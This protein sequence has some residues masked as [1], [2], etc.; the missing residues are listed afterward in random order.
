MC[1]I[2]GYIG[3]RNA[4]PILLEGLKR[5]EYRGYDSAGI[6]FYENGG[7]VVKKTVG[8]LSNLE[9]KINGQEY[10]S[11]IG[12]GHTRWATHGRPT[13]I[14][15][16]PHCDC[17]GRVVV[18]HNGIIENHA[19]LRDALASEGHVF[20]SQTDTE[21]V[22]HL[23][24]KYLVECKDLRD[25]VLRA[26]GE[27]KGTFALAVISNLNPDKMVV[28]R[29]SSPLVIGCGR[30]EY[31]VASDVTPLLRYTRDAIFLD[32]NEIAVLDKNGLEVFD[33]ESGCRK[34]KSTYHVTW[35]ADLAEKNGYPHF[36]LKE[37]HEQPQAI[38]NTWSGITLVD[39][40]YG[41][42]WR[43][44]NLSRDE[45][46]NMSRIYLVACG[47]SWHASLIGK[48]MIESL[49]RIPVEVDLASEFRY[50]S[51]LID[52]RTLTI[53]IT[54]SGETA[55]TLGAMRKAKAE[56]SKVLTICNVVESSAT[57]E[58]DG[59]I[60]THAGPEIG[61][62]STKA[63]T[64]QLV[65]LY[66]FALF[67]GR[68][69]GLVS[70]I[71]FC[72]FISELKKIPE[73]IEKVIERESEIENLANLYWER[74]NF[75]FL[76]RGVTYPVALEGALKLKEISYIHAEGYA[77]GEMKHGP[78]A[79]IDEDMVVVALVPRNSIYEKMLGNVEEVKAREGTVIALTTLGDRYLRS[80]VDHVFYVPKSNDLLTPILYTVPL[81][82]LA[83]YIAR[84]RGCDIDQ[85]RNLAKSVTV[86]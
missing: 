81:Q 16:H 82:L 48:F 62:A 20:S 26:L 30:G 39:G 43:D 66:M 22:S 12:I 68:V 83:Y 36:M 69:R 7:I 75:L 44:L 35:D 80:K 85:P 40:K 47:T 63:F 65:A 8:K 1:G 64:S 72:K 37:I 56:G 14:N 54:Q 15:A 23:I 11:T 77:G 38:R 57:R 67:L 33:V 34:Q 5:L 74:K 58:A 13:E 52:N 25:A 53:G 73:S 6:A 55:D 31:F 51:P 45:I 61:V 70:D 42:E 49:A 9:S 19:L 78:I 79:L 4:I 17:S 76:G 21:V 24:E 84:N 60:Y 10:I 41:P 32:D 28:A 18:V 27:I 59:V 50:R 29:R 3:D 86:E 71:L 2:V 46:L